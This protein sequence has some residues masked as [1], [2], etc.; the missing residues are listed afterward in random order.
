MKD[1]I[2]RNVPKFPIFGMN[3]VFLSPFN[4][5]LISEMLKF[6]SLCLGVRIA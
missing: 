4:V 1:L 3:L 5:L 2:L 6:F